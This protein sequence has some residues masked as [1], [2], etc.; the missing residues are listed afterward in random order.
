M[1]VLFAAIGA[2]IA[3]LVE[4]TV[5]PHIG[6]GSAH[7]HPVLVFGVIWALVVGFDG[8][9]AAAFVGGL[10]LDALAGR[11]LGVTALALLL[12]VGGATLIGRWLPRARLL[13]P[14]LATFVLS[15]CFSGILLVATGALEGATPIRD[16]FGALL[17]GAVYDA[18]L[19]VLVGPIAVSIHDRRMAETRIDW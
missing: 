11:P 4:L 5:V 15:L 10:V 7:P 3:A 16:P 13:I 14:V 8:G 2:T 19:A 1:S 9:L 12:S 17:P 6:I 18:F